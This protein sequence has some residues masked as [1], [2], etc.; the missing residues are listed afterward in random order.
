MSGL[1]DLISNWGPENCCFIKWKRRFAIGRND[2]AR[3]S[4]AFS[5]VLLSMLQAHGPNPVKPNLSN[6]SIQIQTG[7]SNSLAL[8][9]F[10]SALLFLFMMN[11]SNF[12]VRALYLTAAI[13]RPLQNWAFNH[14]ANHLFSESKSQPA[15]SQ[16][17][18]AQP[19]RK[20]MSWANQQTTIS[21]I[22]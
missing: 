17:Q 9:L 20:C 16:E 11:R 18:K 4:Y 21:E 8:L 2:R 7:F 12:L 1:L 19:T 13:E 6:N 10:G 3:F 5:I 14:K 15:K 22:C